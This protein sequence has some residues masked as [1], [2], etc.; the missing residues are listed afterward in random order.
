MWLGVPQMALLALM[1]ITVLSAVWAF[2]LINGFVGFV[3]LLSSV[4]VY[5]ILRFMS[6]DDPHRLMQRGKQLET[7]YHARRNKGFWGTH[8]ATPNQFNPIRVS[9]D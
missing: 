3:V 6:A 2:I 7:W 8:S 1:L 4:F 5:S 9:E